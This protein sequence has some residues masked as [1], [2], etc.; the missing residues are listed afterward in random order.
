[1]PVSCGPQPCWRPA[2]SPRGEGG[3]AAPVTVEWWTKPPALPSP[4]L[5]SRP[6]VNHLASRAHGD[7]GD[8]VELVEEGRDGARLRSMAPR[9]ERASLQ[10]FGG[11]VGI[12]TARVSCVGSENG[13]EERASNKMNARSRWQGRAA[14]VVRYGASLSS[15]WD[16]H[17]RKLFPVDV[18]NEFRA[19]IGVVG[20]P[21][22]DDGDGDTGDIDLLDRE[23]A[24]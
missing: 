3:R 6:V 2:G 16:P 4:R 24:A 20:A 12:A 10:P 14:A 11:L 22:A 21:V 15:P 9:G 1:W 23:R 13:R 18:N 19:T 7:E 17:L 8:A 5:V